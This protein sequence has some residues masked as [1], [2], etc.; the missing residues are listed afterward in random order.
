M[1]RSEMRGIKEEFN[2]FGGIFS[3]QHEKIMT[4]HQMN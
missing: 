2:R 3:A 1:E 4:K